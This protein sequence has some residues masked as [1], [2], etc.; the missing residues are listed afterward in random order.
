MY[1]A[2]LLRFTFAKLQFL[3]F[4]RNNNYYQDGIFNV[5]Y[6]RYNVFLI[7]IIHSYIIQ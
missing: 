2:K 4:H 7:H 5:N 3:M 1:T 6:K